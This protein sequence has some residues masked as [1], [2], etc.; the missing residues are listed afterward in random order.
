MGEALTVQARREPGYVIVTVAAQGQRTRLPQRLPQRPAQLGDLARTADETVRLL[1]QMSLDLVHVAKPGPLPGRTT[2]TA[3][4]VVRS[5]PAR[6]SPRVTDS[7]RHGPFG[8]RS[9]VARHPP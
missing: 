3:F 9:M 6:R 7:L 1:G 2:P 4:P 5:G 8:P